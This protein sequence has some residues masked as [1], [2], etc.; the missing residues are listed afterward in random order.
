MINIRNRRALALCL[1]LC[2]MLPFSAALAEGT[3]SGQ[4]GENITWTLEGGTLTLSG[5]GAIPDY[6]ISGSD[7]P[8]EAYAEQIERV[9]IEPG[10]TAIGENAFDNLKNLSEATIPE[11]VT[12]IGKRAFDGINKLESIILPET[13]TDIEAYAFAFTDLKTIHIPASVTHIGDSALFYAELTEISVAAENPAYTA[14]DGVLF[15]KD[16]TELLCYPRQKPQ[17]SYAVPEGVLTIGVD[18]FG[19]AYSLENITLPDSLT[20]IKEGAFDCD[21]VTSIT[22]PAQVSH[23][24]AEALTGYD[25]KKILVDPNNPHFSSADGV[26]FSKDG[27]VLVRYPERKAGESYAIPEGVVSIAPYAF[28]DSSIARVTFP[29][30]LTTIGEYAFYFAAL[31]QLNIPGNVQTIEESAFEVCD[32][33]EAVVLAEGV[34]SLGDYVFFMCDALKTADLPASLTE[35]GRSAFYACDLV[36]IHAPEGSHALTYAQ[37]NEIPYQ[38]K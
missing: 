20:T 2:L 30:S 31:T 36:T 34:Q 15:N 22:L 13:L 11:G 17:V 23:I 33:M 18:A 1:V 12:S 37:E 26:L 3:A 4:A 25:L 8:W 14:I 19:A 38:A 28:A 7:R 9:H 35:I 29:T 32:E 24:D 21:Y 5:Q 27:S 10:I 6:A 16:G